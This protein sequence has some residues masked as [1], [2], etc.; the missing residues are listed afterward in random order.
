M[1]MAER[2]VKNEL[3]NRLL[4][5]AWL[6]EGRS[7]SWR[8]P[9]ELPGFIG[10]LG[11]SGMHRP[12]RLADLRDGSANTMERRSLDVPAGTSSESASGRLTGS[13]TGRRHAGAPSG[14]CSSTRG[15]YS[16]SWM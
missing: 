6:H 12:P 2:G 7:R 3:L 10:A 14:G 9:C 8:R 1:L 5:G 13:R 15:W 16:T 4:A 11:G